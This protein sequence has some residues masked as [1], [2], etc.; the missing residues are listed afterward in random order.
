VSAGKARTA[1]LFRKPT[2]VFEDIIR[3]G[4]TPMLKIDDFTPMQGGVPIVVAGEVVGAIGVSGAASAP[5][6]EVLALAGA[7]AF[8]GQ[9]PGGG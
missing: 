3:R 4:R 5:Q 8:G 7:A 6:D 1:A 9:Q 2:R